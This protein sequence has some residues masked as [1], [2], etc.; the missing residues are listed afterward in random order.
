M[1]DRIDG[2][3]LGYAPQLCI[4]DAKELRD[5]LT[6]IREVSKNELM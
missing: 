5:L 3:V 1:N 2:K 6:C 4:I